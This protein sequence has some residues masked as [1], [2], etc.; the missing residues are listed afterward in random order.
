MEWD[1][2]WY[3]A[4]HGAA[5]LF[6]SRLLAAHLRGRRVRLQAYPCRPAKACHSAV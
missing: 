5:F 6:V 2:R 3:E 4:A 1:P